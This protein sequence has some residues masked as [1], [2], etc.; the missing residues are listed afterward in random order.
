MPRP[1]EFDTQEALE[2]AMGVFW[3]RGYRSASLGDL[4]RAMGIS[5]SSFYDTYGCKRS[6]FLD[7]IDHYRRVVVRDFVARLDAESS[8]RRAVEDALEGVVHAETTGD[9]RRGCL[10]GNCAS[11]V[12]RDDK[13]ASARVVAGMRRVEEG[14]LRA[15]QR[16]QAAGELAADK[17]A[18]GLARFLGQTVYGLHVM[19]QAGRSRAVLRDTARVALSV[20]D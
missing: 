2:R 10:L 11:E 17:D 8:G 5:R 12:S 13:E 18:R 16:A 14:F 15:L 9:P 7:A 4:T 6:L 1:R 20:L 3:T 19:G